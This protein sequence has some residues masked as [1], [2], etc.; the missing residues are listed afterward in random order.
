M[1]GFEGERKKAIPFKITPRE[2]QQVGCRE[3][4]VQAP[5]LL[6]LPPLRML[7]SMKADFFS[8]DGKECKGDF[9]SGSAACTQPELDKGTGKVSLAAG[10]RRPTLFRKLLLKLEE[11][12]ENVLRTT[13]RSKYPGEDEGLNDYS[14]I[15]LSDIW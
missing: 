12:K 9:P 6:L 3:G 2:Q 10:S 13:V 4:E 8:R 11:G 14:P 15:I 7:K 5:T 1:E